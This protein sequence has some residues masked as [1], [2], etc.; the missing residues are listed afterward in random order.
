M[1]AS[2]DPMV[3]IESRDWG[4][5]FQNSDLSGSLSCH[6]ELFFRFTTTMESWHLFFVTART[7][8]PD[9]ASTKENALQAASSILSHATRSSLQLLAA[10]V[11]TQHSAAHFQVYLCQ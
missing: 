5:I 4:R 9:P 10:S 11:R 8:E 2:N 3:I 1:H 7:C 6:Q